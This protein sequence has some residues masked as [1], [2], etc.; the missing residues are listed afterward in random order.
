MARRTSIS[1]V[2]NQNGVSLLYIML[3]IHHSGQEPLISFF[4]SLLTVQQTVSNMHADMAKVQACIN[5]M[6]HIRCLSC[7]RSHV[8]LGVQ[9]QLSYSF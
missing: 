7:A 9:G 1:R 8:P 4:N 2:P 3:E 5:H 6:Q